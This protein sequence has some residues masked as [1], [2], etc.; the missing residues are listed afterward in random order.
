MWA[1]CPQFALAPMPNKGGYPVQTGHGPGMGA[2]HRRRGIVPPDPLTS[3][4]CNAARTPRSRHKSRR[5]GTIRYWANRHGPPSRVG[6]CRSVPLGP[7]WTFLFSLIQHDDCTR[8][9][10]HFFIHQDGWATSRML[11]SRR[12]SPNRISPNGSGIGHPLHPGHD[13][14]V[15]GPRG[16]PGRSC[17]AAT[18]PARPEGTRPAGPRA[19]RRPLSSPRRAGLM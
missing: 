3:V 12:R 11:S 17:P 4:G 9:W 15:P 10:G 13:P 5:G 8:R 18:H 16:R 2:W 7:I 14:P 1:P 19:G 6:F